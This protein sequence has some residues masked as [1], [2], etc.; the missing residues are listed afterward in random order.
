M[1]V[2]RCQYISLDASKGLNGHLY[3][4]QADER[5]STFDFINEDVQVAVL[6]VVA[7]DDR[8][9]YARV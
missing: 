4:G 6:G 5:G 8:P 7:V 2:E 1:Q 3:S 9:K